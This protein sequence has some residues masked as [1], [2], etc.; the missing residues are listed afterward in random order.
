ML[1]PGWHA[2]VHPA[3]RHV[4]ARQ[5]LPWGAPALAPGCRGLCGVAMPLPLQTVSGGHG[6]TGELRCPCVRSAPGPPLPPAW[7]A[8]QRGLTRVRAFRRGRGWPGRDVAFC[9]A[10]RDN[11]CLFLVLGRRFWA[12]VGRSSS[13]GSAGCLPAPTLP[14]LVR[15]ALSPAGCR[16]GP[17]TPPARRRVRAPSRG[18]PPPE[19]VSAAAGPRAAPRTPRS[20]GPLVGGVAGAS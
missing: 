2:A 5:D 9:G 8:R 3:Q 14:A 18:S 15:W 4:W 20:L 13:L 10:L 19:A 17:V 1:E 6:E 12:G 11:Q 7:P 16:A